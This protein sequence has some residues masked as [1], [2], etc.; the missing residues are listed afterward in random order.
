MQ[1]PAKQ[2]GLEPANGAAQQS[3]QSTVQQAASLPEGALQDLPPVEAMTTLL[4]SQPA[5]SPTVEPFIPLEPQVFTSAT[6][7]PSAMPA[8]IVLATFSV[9]LGHYLQVPS[10]LSTQTPRCCIHG[11]HLVAEMWRPAQSSPPPAA[12][13]QP[14]VPPGDSATIPEPVPDVKTSEMPTSSPPET[15]M[16]FEELPTSAAPA[17][18]P[19]AD[20]GFQPSALCK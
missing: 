13:A 10:P 19:S 17:L 2:T 16:F 6:Q 4:P 3:V 11:R 20:V 14:T 12:K 18:A 5:A 7:L 15:M 1:E 9:M 8:V